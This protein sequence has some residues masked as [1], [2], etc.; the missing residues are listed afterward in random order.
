M[1]ISTTDIIGVLALELRPE[2]WP[3]HAALTPQ[4]AGELVIGLGQDLATLVPQVKTLDVVLAA[5]HF[6]PAEA[7]RPGWPLYQRLRELHARAPGH[8]HSTPRL[9][10]FGSD[11]QGQVPL[12]FQA[13][14]AL[15]GGHLRVLPFLL[16]GAEPQRI[17]QVSATLE[18]VLLPNGMAQAHTALLAQSAFQAQIE[19]ARYFTI[20]DLAAMTA[21]QYE[22]QGLA[23]LWPLL[24]TALFSPQ[25][26]YWLD[27]PPEP[28]LC[29]HG[30]EVYMA[31]FE[32]AA[33]RN[34]Y[35][36]PVDDS[37]QQQQYW[38]QYQSRQRQFAAVLQAHGITVRPVLISDGANARAVLLE[39]RVN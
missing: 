22:H 15:H 27:I 34:W 33:W 23:C 12:P 9:L 6:D 13:D 1:S 10:A 5:A 18:N 19:H 11:H 8:H 16:T 7:L 17:Q 2:T 20:N 25:R 36:Y 28:L 3:Q 30:G 21:M 32:L 26:E 29:Y 14:A 35:G 39:N 24:E 4:Q 38:Q 37:A 31:Q